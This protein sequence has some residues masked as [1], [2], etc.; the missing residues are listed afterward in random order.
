MSVWQKQ[1][2]WL[3][4]VFW[5]PKKTLSLEQLKFQHQVLL[6][7]PTVTEG[8]KHHL[9]ETFRSIA[10]ILIW[11]D[12]NDSRVFDFFLEKNMQS[13]F[14]KTL[15]QN[16]GR[17]VCLQ[18]LQTL[19]ILFENIRNETSIYYLLSNNHV[20][21]IIVLK[22]DFSDEEVL[23]YYISFLKT[24]SF[25]LNKHTVH[26]FY[27][28]HLRDFPLYTEAIKFF[29]HSESMVRIAVRTL[30]L[31]VY[32]VDDPPMLEYIRS[33]T[34]APYFSNLVWFIGNHIIELD[35]CLLS[36]AHHLNRGRLESLV[37]EHLDHLHYINDILGL[38]VG[39]LNAVLTDHL[40]DRLFIPLY[41]YSLTDCSMSP[42]GEE[43][44]RISTTIS[45]F[46][47]SQVF[48]TLSDPALITPLAFLILTGDTSLTLPRL[49]QPG[50]K[51]EGSC[52]GVRGFLPPAT[53]L[54]TSLGITGARGYVPARP[55][56]VQRRKGKAEGAEGE[57]GSS[58][59]SQSHMND[60]SAE[61]QGTPQQYTHTVVDSQYV[62]IEATPPSGVAMEVHVP[63]HKKPKESPREERRQPGRTES[64][65]ECH[66][67][68][69]GI[70]IA[71]TVFLDT[72]MGALSVRTDDAR[73]LFTLCLLYA[74]TE[75]KGIHPKLL[76]AFSLRPLPAEEGAPQYNSEV[77]TLL[78]AV[79]D[80]A[81]ATGNS[82]R[83]VTL[84]LA[85]MLLG[86]LLG[87][88]SGPAL[89][90]HHIA[91]VESIYES[92]ILQLRLFYKGPGDEIFLEMFEDEYCN[93]NAFRVKVPFLL[94]DASM[95]LPPTDTPLTGI[96][97]TR[98]LP[99]GETERARK[100][101]RVFFA[102]RSLS[103]QLSHSPEK[104]LPLTNP[105]NSACV[106]DIVD[107]NN[108]DLVSCTVTAGDKC[109]SHFMVVTETEFLL[110]D[111]DRTKLGWGVVHFIAFLQDV[112]ISTD[113][114]DSCALFITVHSH[115]ATQKRPALSAHFQ[116]E[117]HI[118]CMAARQ[119]LQRNRD[120]LRLA[121]MARIAKLLHLPTPE[122]TSQSIPIPRPMQL[123]LDPSPS[124]S[125]HTSPAQ[126]T[127]PLLHPS[128]LSTSVVQRV[129][130]PAESPSHPSNSQEFEM[131]DLQSY[132]HTLLT[133]PTGLSPL[134][135]ST[136]VL[137]PSSSPGEE[138]DSDGSTEVADVSLEPPETEGEHSTAKELPSGPQPDTEH[139][140]VASREHAQA[141][142]HPSIHIV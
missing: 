110:V 141:N 69:H 21:S 81:T 78:L 105:S 91:L 57:E 58:T 10:E 48:L 120:C 106:G 35:E 94:M 32:K 53:S 72:L 97:F 22:L 28:E 20:N 115:S 61:V 136:R 25:K 135:Q 70:P 16:P 83:L 60:L 85:I 114:A 133:P 126:H 8:N 119:C 30:T 5:K 40:L 3:N 103:Q 79:L 34:A 59:E 77:V 100:A 1:K 37:A 131:S 90:D 124:S 67:P 2:N 88:S 84:R 39:P 14:L 107:L 9:V 15:T 130:M 43:S 102:I 99:C 4:E 75:N 66:T 142:T 68:R 80:T 55:M 112:D 13:F 24:L 41:V 71:N 93:E 128:P 63:R 109:S 23:A 86:R 27:N 74:M 45:L 47:L 138:G 54:D 64:P 73:C 6:R 95:L 17:Y 118:R 26:F 62:L 12:Q 52:G 18:L 116:F 139:S 7:N 137:V 104:E 101:M 96:E 50:H 129:F 117:D 108:C 33:K 76:E 29:N 89:H 111:P 36:Q 46:L 19:S 49:L 44:P 127:P 132:N 38:G 123:H 113:P 92:S 98:R 65:P 51:R 121:K 56:N 82:I 11:G 122:A 31:N 42:E 134:V 87:E 140:L 125:P